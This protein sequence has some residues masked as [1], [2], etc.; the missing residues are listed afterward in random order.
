MPFETP[1]EAYQQFLETGQYM[2]HGGHFTGTP[3]EQ[4]AK[5]GAYKHMIPHDVLRD[6]KQGR[7]ERETAA[8]QGLM[9]GRSLEEQGIF[10][11][12]EEGQALWRRI[13]A[14]LGTGLD[15]NKAYDWSG[16]GAREVGTTDMAKW[17]TSRPITSVEQ[18]RWNDFRN[19]GSAQ[20]YWQGYRQQ[21][22]AGLEA[23]GAIARDP[24]TGGYYNPGP[25]GGDRYGPAGQGYNFGAGPLGGGIAASN[26]GVSNRTPNIAPGARTMPQMP[27][28]PKPPTPNFAAGTGQV[29]AAPRTPQMPSMPRNTGFTGGMSRKDPFG[30]I[31][32]AS[33]YYNPNQP[34]GPLPGGGQPMIVHPG[35]EVSVTPANQNPNTGGG[36]QA[37]PPGAVPRPPGAPSLPGRP[38]GTTNEIGPGQAGIPS[39][40]PNGRSPF[41]SN[42]MPMP[43]GTGIVWGPNGPTSGSGGS[44][45]PN[46][47]G[48]NPPGHIP[49][50][51]WNAGTPWGSGLQGA[52]QMDNRSQG[53]SLG[54][55]EREYAGSFGP[56]QTLMNFYGQA[57]GV[58]PTTGQP[59]QGSALDASNRASFG[60]LAPQAQRLS[61]DTEA[62]V[63]A[64]KMQL[65][66]GGARDAAI[67]EAIRGGQ[68]NM[69]GL[70]QN[71]AAEARQ[72]LAQIMAMKKGFDP[73]AYQGGNQA[74]LGAELNA[75]GQD[76]STLLGQRGQDIDALLGQ[77]GQDVQWGLGWGGLANSASQNLWD[78]YFTGRGQDMNQ[79]ATMRGQD[80][81]YQAQ[82]QAIRAQREAQERSWWQDLMGT[83]GSVVGMANPLGGLF[84]G[85]GGGRSSGGGG[86]FS[87]GS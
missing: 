10:N 77:R 75:R 40:M 68:S 53:F 28:P 46:L 70:R 17:G 23:A 11:R 37:G 42:P 48:I 25:G 43:T 19:A 60:M 8:I 21:Q 81:N 62:A 26:W 61:G 6:F 56:E 86:G 65:P 69:L 18:Q 33:G 35:E 71:Q 12:K 44:L 73:S 5:F 39:N 45:T 55:A 54:R 32:A 79:Y 34:P 83:V 3:E 41:E 29:N 67:A 9:E 2:N 15:M 84:G 7:H 64:I 76:L 14:G 50:V 36:F 57:L 85:G 30:V 16:G 87:L 38:G 1:E 82:Q 13:N 47:P 51:G 27:A 58:D 52:G 49:M 22:L 59:L 80:L 72:G 31:S 66:P 24:R 4:Q 20:N 74:L 63:E 78:S